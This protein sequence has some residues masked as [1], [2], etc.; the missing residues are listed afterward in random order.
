[1]KKI[2]IIVVL[3]IS[4][5]GNSQ[6]I[7]EQILNN[8]SEIKSVNIND[9]NF[10]DLEVVGNAVGDAKIVFLGEQDHGDATTFEAKA[11][12]V[13]YL[14]EKK[15]FDVLAFESDFFNI[16]KKADEKQPVE[17]IAKSIYP[18]WTMCSQVKPLFYDYLKKQ[19]ESLII[20]GFDCQMGLISQKDRDSLILEMK[21]YISENMDISKIDYPFFEKIVIKILIGEKVKRANKKMFFKIFSQIT[22]NIKN[23]KT[24]LFKSLENIRAYAKSE[25]YT[26][27]ERDRRD[28]QMGRNIIWLHKIKFPNKK[29][30]IWAHSHHLIRKVANKNGNRKTSFL[31][32]SAGEIVHN[33]FDNDSIYSIGFTSRIG[34]TDRIN[35]IKGYDIKE[36]KKESFEAWVHSKRYNF[37]FVDF[38]NLENTHEV[39]YMK[40]RTHKSVKARWLDCFDGIFYIDKMFPCIK[41]E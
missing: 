19:K 27:R 20:S 35:N 8:V 23:K 41:E 2:I 16:N 25:W 39:F 4:F 37:A 10:S 40:G 15:G 13:K 38:R 29:M 28:I 22:R 33:R 24:F 26:F 30:I 7:K 14:H 21:K 31:N 5:V 3:L 9:D 11:R 6:S 34:R 12:L 32:I 1:M 17:E 18:I 36:P